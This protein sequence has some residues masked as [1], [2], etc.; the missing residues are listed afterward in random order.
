MLDQSNRKMFIL[1]DLNAVKVVP[2]L[3]LGDDKML[4]L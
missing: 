4:K 3:K 2:E 1:V